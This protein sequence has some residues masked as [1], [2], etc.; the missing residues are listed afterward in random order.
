MLTAE[1]V[2]TACY[3]DYA[4]KTTGNAFGTRLSEIGGQ[5]VT[6]QNGARRNEAALPAAVPEI[7]EARHRRSKLVDDGRLHQGSPV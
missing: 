5:C 6:P 2:Y 4:C 7:S 1:G 3:T